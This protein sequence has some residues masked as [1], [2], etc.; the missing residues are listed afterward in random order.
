MNQ[1]SYPN[2]DLK[3]GWL[4][5]NQST[6]DIACNRDLVVPGSIVK[7]DHKM[8]IHTNAGVLVVT[9]KCRVAGY[10]QEIWFSAKGMANILSFKYVLAAGSRSPTIAASRASLS[11]ENTSTRRTYHS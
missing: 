1:S 10:P 7:A 9:Q 5:D 8:R 2:P 6:D 11:T 4:L 3:L